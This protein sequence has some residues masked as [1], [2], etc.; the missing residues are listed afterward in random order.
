[1]SLSLRLLS[2]IREIFTED[3]I[4]S[5]DLIERLKELEESPW[6]YLVERFNPSVLARLLK[7]YG[8]KP[9]PFSGG[10]VRGYYR[11]SFEDPWSRYLDP[12]Q[13]VTPVTPVTLEELDLEAS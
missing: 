3:R 4:T 6:S 13:T 11:K 1:M 7:N 12:V 9:R 5:K 2:D 10:K 8:I